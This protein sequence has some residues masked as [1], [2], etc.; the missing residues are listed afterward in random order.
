MAVQFCSHRVDYSKKFL[1][2]EF[3]VKTEQKIDEIILL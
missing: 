3:L 1:K 2:Q